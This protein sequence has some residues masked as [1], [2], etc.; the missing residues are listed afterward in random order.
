VRARH[1]DYAVGSADA[2]PI[3][4]LRLDLAY[5]GGAFAGWA[6]Q[7]GLRT[8]QGEVESA[9][10]MVLR[11]PYELRLACAGR[12]DAGVH[13]RGQVAHADVPADLWAALT[14]RGVDAPVRRLG[15]V[16]AP[17]VRVREMRIA[18]EGFH[19]RWSALS[20]TYAYR[21]SDLAGGADPLLRSHVLAH[22]G[23]GSG[24]LDLETMNAAA[25]ALLG[26]H[27]F[28][29]YCR[30]RDGASSVRTLLELHWERESDTGLAVM[31]IRA[32]AFCHS[33]VR[34]I[35]GALLPV[36]D[37][38]RP[39]DW[40]AKVLAR[41]RREPDVDVAPPVGLCLERVDYPDDADL[42]AQAERA[43]RYRGSD[44]D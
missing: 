40:P 30:R 31:W 25:G 15:G 13:A 42:A 34:S 9:L 5:D 12:T 43:K 22:T 11:A 26:E 7:P 41:E 44:N 6:R 14:A 28:A 39:V 33:M 27:D 19:A 16:L 23:P 38:R 4:R 32:D 36:G 24:P 37:G 29:S 10:T 1:D 21:V 2:G 17:D 18:P 8:V 35:V 3:A 20:R